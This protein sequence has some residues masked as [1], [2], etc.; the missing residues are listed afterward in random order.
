MPTGA[1]TNSYILSIFVQI[2]DDVEGITKY[3]LT[4]TI[5]ILPDNAKRN[6]L[7]ND[8]MSDDTSTAFV[9]TLKASNIQDCAHNII[10][11]TSMLDYTSNTTNNSSNSTLKTAD[12]LTENYSKVR[13]AMMLTIK[14]IQV[15]GM[16]SAK[17]AASMVTA[18]SENIQQL[19]T[20]SA[21]NIPANRN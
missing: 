8:I 12:A 14:D 5:K 6:Q 15:T 4:E 11:F 13:D 19:T 18:V 21:V 1:S 17:L 20:S 10:S 9:Q 7:I 16:D 3:Y 2:I